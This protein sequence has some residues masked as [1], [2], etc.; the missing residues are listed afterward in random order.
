MDSAFVGSLKKAVVACRDFLV[1]GGIR[2]QISGEL[3]TGEL[4]KGQVV[5]E[6]INDVVALGGDTVILV[7]MI[8]AGVGIAH[9]VEPVHRHAFTK[10]G[11]G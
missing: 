3:L 7:T 8:T 2:K 1:D 9:E 6:G 10:V 4:V 5:V 11:R